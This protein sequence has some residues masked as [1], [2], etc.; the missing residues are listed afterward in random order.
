MNFDDAIKAHSAWKI[1]LST[2]LRKPDGSL[3]AAEIEPDN[4]CALGQ[5]IHGEGATHAS[6]PEFTTLKSE[7]I[8]FHKAAAEVVRKADSGKDTSEETALGGKSEFST[9]S[10]AVITAIM[11]MKRKA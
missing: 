7:H 3:K 4:K 6:L 1:K 9:T 5:W 2:Y 8:K 11:V 10:Q